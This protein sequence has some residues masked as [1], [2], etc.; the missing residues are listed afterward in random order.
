MVSGATT[1]G[2]V[3]PLFVPAD[4][5]E[6]FSKAARS[7]AD[8]IIIDLEDA[9]ATSAKDGARAVLGGRLPDEVPVLVRIN[10]VGTPWYEADIAAT[11]ACGAS[12]VVLPKAEDPGAL[13]DAARA[14]KGRCGLVAL[15]ET[16]RGLASARAIAASGAVARLAFGSFDYS[17]DLG[18]AHGRDALLLARL[19]IVLAS[20]LAGLP[21]PLDGVT[22][23]TG[24]IAAVEADAR[25]ARDLGFGGKLLIHP[26]QVAPTL[27]GF[28]PTEA[29]VV[30]ARRVID[31]ADGAAAVGGEMVDAP[32]R[33]RAQTILGRSREGGSR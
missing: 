7:G 2:I 13:A 24:D 17:A 11:V 23:A 3:A 12:G 32:V 16:A 10:A 29:E 4:R 30:W 19:E 15:I 8:A 28:A 6:R 20:R 18:C 21:A 25:Y 33:L 5:P 26:A 31:T 1:G 9:V 27:D 14:I 22:A